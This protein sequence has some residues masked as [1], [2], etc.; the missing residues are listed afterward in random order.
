MSVTRIIKGGLLTEGIHVNGKLHGHGVRS[1]TDGDVDEG[2][3]LHGILCKQI[4]RVRGAITEAGTFH[5]GYLHGLGKRTE[6]DVIAEGKFGH[7]LLNGNGKL[8]Y[9]AITDEGLFFNDNLHG[10]GIR[11]NSDRLMIEQGGFRKGVLHGRGKR[12]VNK[13][14]QSIEEGMFA[15]GHLIQGKITANGYLSEGAFNG[16]R[17]HGLGKNTHICG[18][19]QEGMFEYGFLCGQGMHIRGAIIETGT[20]QAGYLHGLG[21]RTEDDVIEEGSFKNGSYKGIFSSK[22]IP[23]KGVVAPRRPAVRFIAGGIPYIAASSIQHN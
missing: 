2:M 6:G 12:T 13:P 4:M 11:T 7:G 14:S 8:T 9:G 5:Y 3:F 20:F 15:K 21:K 16:M 23:M 19:T 1:H 17:L 22:K 18:D 10:L